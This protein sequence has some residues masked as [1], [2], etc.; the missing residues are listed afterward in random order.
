MALIMT[1][2][3]QSAL[4]GHASETDMDGLQTLFSLHYTRLGQERL[5][6]KVLHFKAPCLGAYNLPHEL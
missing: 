2:S 5:W 3:H 4:K 1:I 6:A